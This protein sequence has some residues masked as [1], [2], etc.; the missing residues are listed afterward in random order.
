VQGCCTDHVDGM[1]VMR[2]K[3]IGT[4]ELMR[5]DARKIGEN[6][7]CFMESSGLLPIFLDNRSRV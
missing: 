1:G 6:P 2:E 7:P 5:E 4:I 3:R